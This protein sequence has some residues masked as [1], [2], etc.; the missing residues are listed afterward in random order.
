M[1]AKRTEYQL[2][3]VWHP[4]GKS[5]SMK[6]VNNT[7]RDISWPRLVEPVGGVLAVFSFT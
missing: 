1:A 4:A 2:K 3:Q 6:Q 7:S 5:P